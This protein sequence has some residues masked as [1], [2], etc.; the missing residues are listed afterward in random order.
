M[1]NPIAARPLSTITVSRKLKLSQ[2][3]VFAR[4]LD[5]GSF[6]RAGNEL[7]LTQPAISKA[8]SELES[9][10]GE[11]LFTRS[12]RGVTPTGFGIILGRRVQSLIAELRFMTD[13]VHAF[14]NGDSG[15]L[16]VGTLI[17]ASAVLLPR[18]IAQLQREAAGVL[19]TIKEGTAAH[20]FPLLLTGE[21]DVVVGRLPEKDSP[22]FTS[23][24]VKHEALFEEAFCVVAGPGHALAGKANVEIADLTSASWIFPL[25]ESPARMAV[26]RIFQG[27]GV[28]V[29]IPKVESLSLLA[30]IGLMLH[31]NLLSFMPRAAALQLMKA[32]SLTILSTPPTHDLGRVGFSTRADK[33]LP[34]SCRRFIECL[35]RAATEI[36]KTPD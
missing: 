26:E 9:F 12:N 30:N 13:E 35:R 4:V 22:T 8:I 5:S 16:I 11:E 19:V 18:A 24:P 1:R 27:A 23:F 15:H 32:G 34:P 21:I 25:V 7:G 10:F 29:P 33:E 3:M 6:V 36:S 20:L 17:A 2:M 28:S 14:R 31:S